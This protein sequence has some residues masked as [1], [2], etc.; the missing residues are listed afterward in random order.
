MN[1][2]LT[3]FAMKAPALLLLAV[4]PLAA[5]TPPDRVI[6]NARTR[7]ASAELIRAGSL[8]PA[9]AHLRQNLRPEP[10]S[11][12]DQ[13]ALPQSLLD[14]AAEFYNHREYALAREALLQAHLAAEA[15]LAGRTA[16]TAARRA[17]IYSTMGVLYE[18]VLADQR[19]AFACFEAAVTLD[20]H[21]TN[22]RTR[23]A[24]LANR[25]APVKGGPR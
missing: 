2:V 19:T 24:Q 4:L 15:V 6:Q 18:I 17:Q 22:H 21:D 20:P 3:R 23:R 1:L 7:R 25:I 16:A 5:A 10:I 14:I 12:G 8:G 9:V 11:G 13:T